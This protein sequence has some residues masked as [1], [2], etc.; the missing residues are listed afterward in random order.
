MLSSNQQT[1]MT[2]TQAAGRRYRRAKLPKGLAVAW[3]CAQA[4]ELSR[5]DTV[6]L[7]G[8]FIRT[9]HP[10]PVGSSVQMAFNLPEGEVRARAIVRTSKPGEG[11]GVEFV[12]MDPVAR[13]RLQSTL[14]RLLTL[15]E[16][17]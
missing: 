6:A 3:N 8:L 9:S 4:R 17:K 13:S 5:A 7:G 15:S 11:M 2:E 12:G 16:A 14:K 10:Q 1:K